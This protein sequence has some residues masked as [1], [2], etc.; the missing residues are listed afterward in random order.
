MPSEFSTH[1]GGSL[2]HKLLK[3]LSIHL[4]PEMPPQ[5][6][7]QSDARDHRIEH[8]EIDSTVLGITEDDA[9]V[10]ASSNVIKAVVA[11]GRK[12]EALG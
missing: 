8:L 3:K 5:T 6:R 2:E 9:A 10:M 11:A 7:M 12:A 4:R 1:Q